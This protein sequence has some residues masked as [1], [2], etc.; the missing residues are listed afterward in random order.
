MSV[1][2]M[3]RMPIRTLAYEILG[4]E[5]RMR[6]L[7]LSSRC[8]AVARHRQGTDGCRR[9]RFDAE[10]LEDMLQ[11]FLNGARADRKNGRDLGIG[12]SRGNQGQNLPFAFRHGQLLEVSGLRV[13]TLAFQD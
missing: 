7:P 11:M 13:E 12:F 8:R 10:L 4:G 1:R 3:L 2:A 5:N 6:R 9:A